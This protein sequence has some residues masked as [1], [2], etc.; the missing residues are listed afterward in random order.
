MD[1]S[2]ISPQEL[3]SIKFEINNTH[4]QELSTKWTSPHSFHK[5]PT[6]TCWLQ[7]SFSVGRARYSSPC[8]LRSTTLSPRKVKREHTSVTTAKGLHQDPEAWEFYPGERD[9]EFPSQIQPPPWEVVFNCSLKSLSKLLKALSAHSGR[10]CWT[11]EQSF[12]LLCSPRRWNFGLSF[13]FP[14]SL[15][16]TILGRQLMR[17]GGLTSFPQ[18]AFRF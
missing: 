5:P 18:Q 15:P 9:Q 2:L 6:P 3:S 4:G 13:H 8:V 7:I 12:F 14:L 10:L 1:C 11:P 17:W 16:A